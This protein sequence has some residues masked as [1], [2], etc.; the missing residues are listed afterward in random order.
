MGSLETWGA[1]G[2]GEG[3]GQGELEAKGAVEST[4]APERW[5]GGVSWGV[6]ALLGTRGGSRL[7][8]HTGAGMEGFWS[9]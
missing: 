2:G 9:S 7:P 3:E 4:W 1:M 8:G 6:P 5:W